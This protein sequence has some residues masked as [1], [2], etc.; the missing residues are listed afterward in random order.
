MIN[1][2]KYM[3]LSMKGQMFDGY[4]K[5]IL[6]LCAR[7]VLGEMKTKYVDIKEEITNEIQYKMLQKMKKDRE[8]SI[9]IYGEAFEKSKSD[10]AKNNLETAKNELKTIEL[11]LSELEA[12]MPQKMD[13]EETR[14]FVKDL[15]S[16]FEEKPNIGIVMKS[17][18]EYKEKQIDMSLASRIVKEEL[19]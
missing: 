1:I 5:D 8:N 11:F 4:D 14:N 10:I 16:K 9:Q 17:L 19:K 18:K 2:Q 13:E 12:E 7:H 15:I 3:T 6:N